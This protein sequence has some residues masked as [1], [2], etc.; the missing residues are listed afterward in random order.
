MNIKFQEKLNKIIKKNNSLLCIGLDPD[1]SKFPKHLVSTSESIFVFNKAIIDATHD[2]VCAYKPNIA[3]YEAYGIGGLTQLKKTIDY[4]KSSY[5]YIPIVLDAKRADIPNT[6]K[7][8]A[9]ALYEYWDADATTV[10]PYLGLDS[11]EPFLSYKDKCTILLIKTSNKDSKVFQDLNFTNTNKPFYQ[12]MAEEIVKWNYPNIGIF[13][14]ATYPIELE[15]IRKIFPDKV[16]L[17]AGIGTQAAEV[18]SAVKA[19]IDKDKGGIMF[20]AGRSIIYRS[21]D[22]D[23]AEKSRDEAK[24]LRDLM[25]KYR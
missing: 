21:K 2:I 8:Y 16:F 22:E 17:S 9:K 20:N 14:G 5:P 13:V 23:F 24:R 6:A 7:M 25:N 19:G 10:Y 12:V 1:L 11:I 4:L 15:I 3:F 18:E